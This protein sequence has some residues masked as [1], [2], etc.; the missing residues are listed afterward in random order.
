MASWYSRQLLQ[1]QHVPKRSQY[2]PPPLSASQSAW[3][4]QS[5]SDG[6]VLAAEVVGSA[7][8]AE[9]N[10]PQHQIASTNQHLRATSTQQ[11]I[12]HHTACVGWHGA[13]RCARNG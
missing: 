7:Q 11:S 8:P 10:W 12:V 4:L 3:A 2:N 1:D 9:V 5:V 6:T 13:A